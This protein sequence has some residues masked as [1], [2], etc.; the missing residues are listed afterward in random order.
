MTLDNMLIQLNSDASNSTVLLL[1]SDTLGVSTMT[2]SDY[3]WRIL[4][5]RSA[6]GGK[7]LS[8]LVDLIPDAFE[9]HDPQLILDNGILY[10]IWQEYDSDYRTDIFFAKSTDFGLT[11]TK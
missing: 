2:E 8:G 4:T 1:W 5:V 3:G 9:A 7:T 10:L 11:F 6:D